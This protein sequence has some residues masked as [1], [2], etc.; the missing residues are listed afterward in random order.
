MWW[1]PLTWFRPAWVDVVR[2]PEGTR[3][4]VELVAAHLTDQAERG[5]H[6]IPMSRATRTG[7]KFTVDLPIRD[8]AQEA[9]SRAQKQYFD[10]YPDADRSSLIWH[11]EETDAL[12]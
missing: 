1:N 10:Q 2:E 4:Q 12:T 7:A 8:F 11:V 3:D 6:G 5:P 9:L